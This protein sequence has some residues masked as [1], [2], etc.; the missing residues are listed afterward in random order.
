[1]DIK[2]IQIDFSLLKPKQHREVIRVLIDVGQE[3]DKTNYQQ[4]D[5][6]RYC[7]EY[8]CFR[9]FKNP[10]YALKTLDY[11]SFMHSFKTKVAKKMFITENEFRILENNYN[12]IGK[13][14]N[15]FKT[16]RNE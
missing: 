1:M 3:V 10:H 11:D 4:F 5:Y 8:E 13:I 9:L 12:E 6:L 14:L 15:N 2:Q 16:L 7:D